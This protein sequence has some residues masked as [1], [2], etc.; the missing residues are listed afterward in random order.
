MPRV[1]PPTKP[2]YALVAPAHRMTQGGRDV[3]HTVLRMHQF[4]QAVPDSVNEDVNREHQRRFM[5]AHAKAILDYIARN[6]EWLLG[7]VTLS[8]SSPFVEFEE[9]PSSEEGSGPSSLPTLGELRLREG[10]HAALRMIDGQHRRRAIRDFLS[11]TEGDPERLVKFSESQMP[12]AIYVEDDIQAIRQ[13]FSDLAQQRKMDPV[14][15]TKFNT[16]DPFNRAAAEIRSKSW[17]GPFVDEEYSR[18]RIE[19]PKLLSLNQL[20]DCL[21]TL[22]HGYGGRVSR[23]RMLAANVGYDKLVSDGLAWTDSFLPKARSE[24]QALRSGELKSEQMPDLRLNSLALNHMTLRLIA[25]CLAEW[26]RRWPQLDAEP[27]ASFLAELELGRGQVSQDLV[28][29]GVIEPNGASIISRVQVMK[30][31]IQALV[32]S[33]HDRARA[34]RVV[35]NAHHEST[36]PAR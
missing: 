32:E 21:R 17:I 11:S 25:G 6:D 33:A 18:I 8:V 30:P 15:T 10:A 14:T 27:L 34:E 36:K 16:R 12:V 20:A 4:D 23:A 9:Y 31:A 29:T 24:F 3:Y 28:E 26:E 13:M 22:R 35:A 1:I 19:S 5:P 2:S 7:P